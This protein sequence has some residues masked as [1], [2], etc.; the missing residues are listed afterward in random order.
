MQ[1]KENAYK[2]VEE[3]NCIPG[4]SIFLKEGRI[5]VLIFQ[6]MKQNKMRPN[7]KGIKFESRIILATALGCL[8]GPS[9]HMKPG[10]S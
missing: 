5:I 4:R 1:D 9:V 7:R 2:S 10:V 8:L 6:K 3:F